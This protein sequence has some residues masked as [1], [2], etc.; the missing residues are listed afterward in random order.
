MS[1]TTTRTLSLLL[2]AL[3]FACEAPDEADALREPTRADSSEAAVAAT[4]PPVADTCTPAVLAVYPSCESALAGNPSGQTGCYLVGTGASRSAKL[5]VK[6]RLLL[7]Q[8]DD[9]GQLPNGPPAD[10]AYLTA[11]IDGLKAYFDKVSYGRLVFDVEVAGNKQR[12]RA[13]RWFVVSPTGKRV[14]DLS[15]AFCDGELDHPLDEYDMIGTLSTAQGASSGTQASQVTYET[16]CSPRRTDERRIAN[17]IKYGYRDVH[18][19][20]RDAA[21]TH[22]PGHALGLLHDQSYSTLQGRGARSSLNGGLVEYGGR[23]SCMGADGAGVSVGLNLPERVEL[24]WLNDGAVGLGRHVF[25]IQNPVSRTLTIDTLERDAE[26]FKG[27]YLPTSTGGYWVEARRD[28]ELEP[29]LQSGLIIHHQLSGAKNEG[30]MVDA[31]LDTAGDKAD[32]LP[33]G[34]TYAD[35][36][37]GIYVT[38]L[39][40]TAKTATLQVE[41]DPVNKSAPQIANVRVAIVGDAAGRFTVTA[42]DADGDPLSYSWRFGGEYASGATVVKSLP[43][44]VSMR[45]V[46]TVSDRKGGTATG[47]VDWPSAAAYSGDWSAPTAGRVALTPV[48]VDHSVAD[49]E[50][51]FALSDVASVEALVYDWT[52]QGTQH[53]SW[54]QPIFGFGRINASAPE[55]VPF[56][57]TATDLAACSAHTDCAIVRAGCAP[58]PL[59]LTYD[60]QVQ[61]ASVS[62]DPALFDGAPSIS[63]S[64]DDCAIAPGVTVAQVGPGCHVRVQLAACPAGGNNCAGAFAATMTTQ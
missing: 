2:C 21:P 44:S 51:I 4:A 62:Y 61:L 40:E 26:G 5:C 45:V 37:N 38:A 32:G 57:V 53:S 35:A 6:K 43:L 24:G 29:S 47:T 27:V 14:P 11:M 17:F 39:S 48:A 59:R 19:T 15:H 42:S 41:R 60:P 34:R 63:W 12:S 22:E 13:E 56:R 31:T 9:D 28:A 25:S 1:S 8:L 36:L 55:C 58:V 20:E 18:E 10:E 64:S 50:F 52:I 54:P 30:Q 23:S 33:V 46:V 7:V 16:G 3:L 49:N